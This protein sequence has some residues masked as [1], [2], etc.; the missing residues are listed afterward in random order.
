MLRELSIIAPLIFGAVLQQAWAVDIAIENS[1]FEQLV[2]SCSPQNSCRAEKNVPGWTGSTNF[3][4][5]KPT[6]NRDGS[7][8]VFPAGVPEGANAAELN[9]EGDLAQTLAAT[10]QPD[11]TYM[12]V[13]Y[14]GAQAAGGYPFP[15]GGYSVELQAGSTI[16]ATDS[17]LSPGP[18][19]FAA[20]RIV[21]SSRT[22]NP[23]QRLGIRLK[24]WGSGV[25]YLDKISLDATPNLI[26][27]SASQIASGGGW[28]TTLTLINMAS[29]SN[30]V[31]FAFRM[32]DGRPLTL[33]LA[34]TQRGASENATASSLDRT[35]DAGATLLVESEAPVSA[36]PLVGWAEVNSSQ[37]VAG[38]AIFRQRSRDGRD[39]EGT[40]ALET[41]RGSRL[42]LPFDNSAGFATAVAIVNLTGDAA[43][44]NATIR[45]DNGAQI[46]SQPFALTG[47]GHTSFAIGERF[48]ITNGRRGS[49]EFQTRVVERSQDWGRD[50]TRPE[51][52]RPY[53]SPFRSN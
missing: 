14:F 1:G 33:P 38:F 26:P 28:K 24:N 21:Y 45:D 20:G 27:G 4:T 29:G 23:G 46:D 7:F 22:V 49:I 12:L 51:A 42:L 39:A 32:D 30:S 5:V 43:T 25:V 16:L 9:Y 17:S 41:T 34:I 36:A 2:L 6:T 19:T 10:L 47:M 52:S 15:A 11:T 48:P 18:G 3:S 44:I 8:P 37:P 50:L 53:R 13:Y 35:L 40:A 31:K